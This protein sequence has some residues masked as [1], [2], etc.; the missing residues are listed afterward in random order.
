M[1]QGDESEYSSSMISDSEKESVFTAG[2]VNLEAVLLAEFGEFRLFD[3]LIKCSHILHC[4]SK[5]PVG[6]SD[7][8]AYHSLVKG[9]V[10]G[11]PHE[12]Y[13]GPN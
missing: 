6:H 12:H 11:P 1:I 10:E 13:D 8:L 9:A 5:L 3:R 4:A 7:R 2:F